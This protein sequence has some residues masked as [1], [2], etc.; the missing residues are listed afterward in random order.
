VGRTQAIGSVQFLG[1]AYRF[2]KPVEVAKS[3]P[4]RTLSYVEGAFWKFAP[5]SEH[6]PGDFGKRKAVGTTWQLKKGK[7]LRKKGKNQVRG[8]A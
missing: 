8:S 3:V 7:M 6:T 4:K 2:R 1:N 5:K